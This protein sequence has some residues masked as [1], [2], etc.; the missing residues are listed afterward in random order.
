M[1]VTE[2]I[3]NIAVVGFTIGVAAKSYE[4]LNKPTKK[5]KKCKSIWR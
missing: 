2:D 5:I 1:S 4:L 3:T